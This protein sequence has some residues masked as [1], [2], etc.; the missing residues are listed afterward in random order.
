[1]FGILCHDGPHAERHARIAS[2]CWYLVVLEIVLQMVQSFCF[3]QCPWPF[4]S[5]FPKRSARHES[6]HVC[7]RLQLF[8]GNMQQL[9]D[10][11]G[12]D[13]Q[14]EIGNRYGSIVK[15]HGLL[16]ASTRALIPWFL[17]TD[18]LG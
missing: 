17:S 7:L 11:H 18:T 6:D 10:R 15:F 13:F 1:M 5:I 2:S 3:R 14:E 12:G 4:C 16:G 8:T 9:L